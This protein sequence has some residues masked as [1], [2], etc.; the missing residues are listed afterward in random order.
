MVAERARG[1]QGGTINANCRLRSRIAII[2]LVDPEKMMPSGKIESF[3]QNR[4]ELAMQFEQIFNRL[5]E[6]EECIYNPTTSEG[7]E[8]YG[9]LGSQSF[10]DVHQIV[11]SI[12]GIELTAASIIDAVAL[13][14]NGRD[15]V[16]VNDTEENDCSVHGYIAKSDGE[17]ILPPKVRNIIVKKL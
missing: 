1:D 3:D 6:L 5:S 2:P 16:L 12:R 4:S 8:R 15:M 9:G 11:E 14:L 13:Y 17:R 7:G 10:D